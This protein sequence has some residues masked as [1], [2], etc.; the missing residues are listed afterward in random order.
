MSES[1]HGMWSSRLM[2]ILAA[3]GS[4]VGLGNIWRFPYVAG[5]NGGAAFVLAYLVCIFL[6]GVP[7]MVAEITLGRA[8]RKSPINTMQDLTIQSGASSGWRVIGWMGALAGFMILS[9]YAVIAGWA[10][11]YLVEMASGTFT[12]ADGEF[13]SE[14]FTQLTANPWTVI[15]WHTLFMALTTFIAARGVGA[16]LEATVKYLMPTLFVLLLALVGWAAVSSGH[17]MEG[18]NFLFAFKADQFSTDSV[19]MAMGQAF[20][21]LSLGMGAI[22]A[23]GA[24]LPKSAS[25]MSSAVTIAALDTLVAL[26]SGMVIF[27]IVFANGLEPSAGPGLMFITLP[28]A[29][30]Q[31]AAG[32]FFGSLFFLLVV[33]AAITSAISLVEPAI[34]WLVE[35]LEVG[36]VTA[37]CMIGGSGWF[38]GLGSAFSFNLWSDLTFL[39][40]KTFF[41]SMDYVANNI[42]LP[43]G[44][45]LIAV[46]AGWV[47]S[48][49]IF[50][51]QLDE[52]SS[53]LRS[54]LRFLIRIV[55]P[56]AVF[57][58]FLMTVFFS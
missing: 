55:A 28:L 22:M 15:G 2:F 33:F 3:A 25:I 45:V 53:G 50:D 37:A 46:F 19:L 51:E 1:V 32:Q 35:K 34:A 5:E 58:V 52:L 43:I 17:F 56:L 24:Y 54:V 29:F 57:I 26:L 39:P 6:I 7:I 31:M 47:L 16:G 44:G 18:L 30:G 36:R 14:T 8:G 9:F 23:Y 21:T 12:G 48:E 41:D 40:G 10:I 49:K 4:A 13:A 20:F 42:M 27:P 11:A 38:V